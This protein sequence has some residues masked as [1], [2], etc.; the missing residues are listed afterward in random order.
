MKL[1]CTGNS[2]RWMTSHGREST[3]SSGLALLYERPEVRNVPSVMLGS[4]RII[5]IGNPRFPLKGSFKG[6]IDTGIESYHRKP[7]AVSVVLNGSEHF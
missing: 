5:E 6:D 2:L 7:L 3:N 4:F 1:S